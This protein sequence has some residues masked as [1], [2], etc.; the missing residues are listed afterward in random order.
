MWLAYA[1]TDSPVGLAAWMVEQLQAWSDCEGDL[2][3]SIPRDVLLTNITLYWITAATNSS[4]WLR[5]VRLPLT[6]S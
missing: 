5:E 1:L 4:A 3:R 6:A 2:E